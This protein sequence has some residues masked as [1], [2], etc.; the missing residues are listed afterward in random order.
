MMI[1]L[2]RE[3]TDMAACAAGDRSRKGSDGLHHIIRLLAERADIKPPES[4]FYNYFLMT[5]FPPIYGLR[6][7]G[8]RTLPSSQRLFSRNAISIRGGA[9]T[10]LFSV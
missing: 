4:G 10:V 9:T 3:N 2:M 6:A 1:C 5:S 7:T 8:I